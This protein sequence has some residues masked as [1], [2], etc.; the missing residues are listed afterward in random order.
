M[1]T[2]QVR[3]RG[4]ALIAV[5]LLLLLLSALSVGLMYMVNSEGRSGTNDVQNSLAYRGAEGGMEKMTA[6]LQGLYQSSQAPTVANIAALGNPAMRPTIANVTFNEYTLT[7]PVDVN[8]NPISTYGIISTGP[9]AGLEA[10]KVPINLATTAQMPGGQQVRMLRTVE[11]ALI[12]VF[13]FGV[14]SQGDLAYHAGP[15]FDFAGRV[16]TNGN[17]FISDGGKLTF[18][19]KITAVGQVIRQTLPNGF[20]TSSGYTG[21]VYIPNAPGGCDS[22]QPSANCIAIG[23]AQGSQVG[24]LNSA[25]NPPWNGISLTTYN[26]YIINGRTGAQPLNLPFVGAGVGPVQIIRRPPPGEL[27]GSQLASSRLYNQA[28]IR[29]LLS[30]TWQENHPLDTNPVQDADDVELVSQLPA[31]LL[32]ITGG[33]GWAQ[34]GVN[35]AGVGVS[36]FGQATTDCINEPATGNC[37][38][39][40]VVPPFFHGVAFPA[41]AGFTNS[42][43]QWPTVD[44]WVRVDYLGTDG[45]YHPITREWLSYGFA[46]DPLPPMPAN[47]HVN[48]VHPKAI[49]IFQQQADRNGNGVISNGLVSGV[50]PSGVYESTAVVGVNS[51]YNW[52]P[53]NFYDPR[54]GEARDT[55]SGKAAGSCTPNGVM[56]AVELDVANLNQWL[57]GNYGGTGAQV[58]WSKQNG[59]LLYFSDRR[60]MALDTNTAPQVKTGESGIEDVVNP[61]VAS[62]VPDGILDPSEDVD[63]NGQKDFW[64]ELNIG[65]GFGINTRTNPANPFGATRIAVC[66]T[67]GRKNVVTGARHIL[68]LVDGSRGT[69]PTQPTGTGGFTVGSEN[70]VYVLGDY[71]A[72]ASENSW[73]DPHAD[74]AII[75]DAVTVLSNKW[76]DQNDFNNTLNM[77]NRNSIDTRYRMAIAA[78]KGIYFQLPAWGSTD[79]GSDG[80]VHNF[81]RYIEDW[82]G[83]NLWYQGSIVNLYY[84]QYATGTFKCCTVVY[85]PPSRQYSFDVDFLNPAKLPP[86]TPMFRDIDNTSY[87]QDFTPH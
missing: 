33:A 73:A 87:N 64:G 69:L 51:Q 44:G 82:S 15:D 10:E 47:N 6:D 3:S 45:N 43:P 16:H 32:A 21:P 23:L 70:P 52:F 58:D 11:V 25:N 20:P 28:Q 79:D 59:Y 41:P 24:G 34:N 13:Q 72:K 49:L 86:A 5:M 76:N 63:G 7:S 60:N 84:S 4:F 30:D 39:D 66:S 17:L 56:N 2:K 27:P 57:K 77:T 85:S 71:N 48:T 65:D 50:A 55:T 40:F 75:S 74:A 19:S 8:G 12:P 35:V 9:N 29:V 81:I 83:T 53:I 42:K 38:A 67:T 36:Y 14:F 80:G 31:P 61:P 22:A 62:G 18:H 46:R 1:P 26:G 54:E 68:R 78:G 37:D